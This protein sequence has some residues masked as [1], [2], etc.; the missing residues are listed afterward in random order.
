MNILSFIKLGNQ[1]NESGSETTPPYTSWLA[2]F[3][4]RP[5]ACPIKIEGIVMPSVVRKSMTFRLL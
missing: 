1:F 4:Q 5:I 2:K 3:P